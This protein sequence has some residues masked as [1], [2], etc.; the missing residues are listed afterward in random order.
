MSS[1]LL[2]ELKESR[3]LRRLSCCAKNTPVT[4]AYWILELLHFKKLLTAFLDLISCSSI[5]LMGFIA[6][7]RIHNDEKD[8]KI[9]H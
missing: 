9:A 3:R 4:L 5:L 2:V 1:V 6:H 7:Y 8:S